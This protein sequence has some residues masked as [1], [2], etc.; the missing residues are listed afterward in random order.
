MGRLSRPGGPAR[1]RHTARLA[2]V[3]AVAVATCTIGVGAVRPAAAAPGQRVTLIGDSVMAALNFSAEARNVIGSA[4]PMNLDAKV[5]RRLVAPSCSYQGTTP[6]TALQVVQANAGR[7]G[8]VVVV[9]VGYNDS[10][11]TYG[12]QLDQVMAAITRQGVRH[13]VWVTL[14]QAGSNAGGYAN[15]NAAIRSGAARWSELRVADWNAYSTGQPW[16]GGDSLHLTGT[17]AVQLARLVRSHL[18]AIPGRD[19][20]CDPATAIG[21]PAPPLAALPPDAPANGSRLTALTPR[22]LIDTRADGPTGLLGNG[23]VLDVPVAGRDGVP[24][25]ATGAIVNLTVVGA[26]AAGFG[27]VYAAGA[28]NPPLAS[29]ANFATGQTVAGLA[30]ARIGSGGAI[31]VYTSAQA[32]VIVDLV[33]YLHPT[34]G[35]AFHAIDPTRIHDSRPV[36]VGAGQE[37]AIPVRGARGAI[38]NDPSVTGAVLNLTVTE[39]STTGYLTMYPGP[40]KAAARPV[41]S[42][43]NYVAGL[44]IANLVLAAVGSD[45]TVCVFAET[46]AKVVVDAAG[47]LGGS[48]GS[49]FRGVLPQ[50]LVDTRPGSPALH[51][52]IKVKA[53]STPV[54]I[55]VGVT[56][57]VPASATA[58]ALNVTAVAP[59]APGYLTVYPC[60]R[61]L[62]LAS[63]VNYVAGAARPNLAVVRVGAADDVCVVSE[64][65]TDIVVDL[66][67]WF[68]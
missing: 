1:D 44:T 43:L 18:D 22:R 7:L 36:A 64:W 68:A 24:A 12:G 13:V 3:L 48:G 21:L 33:G 63:N 17:G 55:P 25:D 10:W 38:P 45:G 56:S 46:P 34:Q 39:P 59:P 29:N 31:S 2:V 47:W 19:P 52:G 9:D 53:S 49:T 30:V 14:R 5:C 42:N 40:C 28:A 15:I 67:G 37:I 23:R 20:R 6:L 54:A 51:A 32:D 58:V 35:A 8:D 41:A 26:C 11:P 65:P 60:D 57:G 16:F 27:I 50:R 66:A 4:Y 61:P 62:P